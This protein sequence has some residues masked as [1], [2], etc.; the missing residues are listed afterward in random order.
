M[1]SAVDP[2]SYRSV[3]FG[4]EGPRLSAAERE[5][6]TAEPPFGF[7]LF[8]R[9]VEDPAQLREL[10]RSLRDVT[11]R[12]ATPILIDQEGGRVQRLRAPHWF[13]ARPFGFFGEL[14]ARDAERAIEML[15]LTTRLI[16]ADLREAGISVD[17]TPCLDLRLP[18]TVGAIGDRAFA[19]DPNIVARLG[20]VVAEELLKAGILPVI[21]H[22]PGH[23]RATVDS[24]LELPHVAT[25]REE[26]GR[27]D[28]MP[29]HLLSPL[30]WAMTSHIVFSDIDPAQPAT[31]SKTI[32][33]EIIRGEIGFN[34]LLLSDDINMQALAGSLGARAAKALAA[35]V[36]IVLHCSGRLE[37]MREVAACCP[38][39]GEATRARI[40]QGERIQS[41]GTGPLDREA[42]SVR[43]A[44]LLAEGIV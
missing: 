8:A 26:L 36:D 29:F 35:G 39:P 22:L 43:L 40:D 9:N 5:F 21:K 4:L 28:F 42:D 31:H 13:E 10:V 3:I 6:F 37:E 18:E 7:I 38:P 24:H 12:A 1:L 33:D 34:G 17:C 19:A 23:G 16:A 25:P 30:P 20:A 44:E 15:R 11:G 27:M 14:Y 41:A 32:I 2:G